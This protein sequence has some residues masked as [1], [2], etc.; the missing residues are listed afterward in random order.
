MPFRLPLLLPTVHHHRALQEGQLFRWRAVI[1]PLIKNEKFD[2][3]S[4]LVYERWKSKN[5]GVQLKSESNEYL[6]H[7][8]MINKEWLH[9]KD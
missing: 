3:N 1:M 5:Y 8:F 6:L 4:D 7:S 2:H 9:F